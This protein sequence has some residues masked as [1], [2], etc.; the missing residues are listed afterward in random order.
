M[1]LRASWAIL[2]AA[3]AACA[4]HGGPARAAPAPVAACEPHQGRLNFICDMANVEDMVAVPGGRWIIG[5]SFRVGASTPA[6]SVGFYLIDARARTAK[7]AALMGGS[8][9]TEGPFAGCAAPD[10][11]TLNTHG[12]DLRVGS[13]GVHTLYAVNHSGRESIEVFRLD[14]R[15]AEPSLT[16]TGCVLLPA[17]VNGNSV[18]VLPNGGF[19]ISKFQGADDKGGIVGILNGA[20]SGGVYVWRP[21]GGFAEL[22]SG[23]LSGDNGMVAS[24]DGKWLFVNAYGGQAIWRLSLDGSAPPK[25]APVDFRPD[26]LRWAPD[27]KILA[28]GQFIMPE[29][30]RGLHGW[31]VVR[32][33]PETMATTPVMREPGTAAFDNATTALPVAGMLWIGSYT[34]H[35]VGYT[36]AK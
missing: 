24:P 23:R 29:T 13:G 6:P 17:G 27:G 26:N 34:S 15:G 10:I 22:P 16:W 31:A 35:Q 7:P 5:S 36:P 14:A 2:A 33:D 21:G 1:A 4:L 28:T 18:A 30:L 11:K 19:A 8:T 20:V 12:L 25:S 3:L 32:L 9:P